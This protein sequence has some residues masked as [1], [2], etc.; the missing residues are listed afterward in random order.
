MKLV[1]PSMLLAV[2]LGCQ[3]NDSGA[4]ADR[5]A[6]SPAESGSTTDAGSQRPPI[7]FAKDVEPADRFA[8]RAAEL[9]ERFK[10]QVGPFLARHCVRCHGEKK[11][12]SGIRVDRLDGGLEERWLPL[13]KGIRR[14]VVE[15]TMP[16][17][18]E[19]QPTAQEREVLDG[20]ISEALATAR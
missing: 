18:D 7:L 13:W 20:W 5:P 17:E 8:E 14:N 19:P 10:T 3:G 1:V 15:G 9:K 4:D 6:A 12:E 16:P 2:V 11:I